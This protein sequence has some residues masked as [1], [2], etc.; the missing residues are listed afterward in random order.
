MSAD[1]NEA[2]FSRNK[3]LNNYLN[4]IRGWT[5]R[6][7]GLKNIDFLLT[8]KFVVGF[9]EERDLSLNLLLTGNYKRSVNLFDQREVLHR[10][11]IVALIEKGIIDSS[12]NI[13]DAGSQNGDCSLV[14]A[15]MIEGVVY[16]VDPSP[17]NLSFIKKTAYLN[18]I[19]NIILLNYALGN[20]DGYL[21]PLHDLSHTNFS[22]T[23]TTKYSDKN[24]V[25]ATTLDKLLARDEINSIG[26][27]HLDVE[28]MELE[29]LQGAQKLLESAAPVVTFEAHISIDPL[30]KIFSLLKALGY[31]VFM[32]NES[33]PGGR[34]DCIN[35]LALPKSDKID[36][37][38][39]YLNSIKPVQPFYKSTIGENLILIT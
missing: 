3:K 38:A 27:I 11:L 25:V 35:F 17:I 23:P 36:E 2:M 29:V 18:N 33:T 24:K 16:A 10:A 30:E 37:D 13:I 7:I 6:K 15:K 19:P 12:R 39:R 1:K 28:G 22:K 20:S 31:R 9:Q 4:R 8:R 5:S 21:Y 14:W 32:I 26:F 34:P